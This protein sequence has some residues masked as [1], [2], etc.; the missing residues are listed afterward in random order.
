MRK[1]GTNHKNGIFVVVCVMCAILLLRCLPS[2]DYRFSALNGRSINAANYLSGWNSRGKA[3]DVMKRPMT[4]TL[5]VLP[6]SL[7]N[8]SYDDERLVQHIR[9]H[10][11]IPPSVGPRVLKTP[12][13]LDYS[14]RN[15]SGIVDTILGGLEGGFFVECGAGN[16]QTYSNSLFLEKVRGWTGLLVEANPHHFSSMLRKNRYAYLLNACLS[17]RPY[18]A[19]LNFSVA[20]LLG[21]LP[22]YIDERQKSRM[23]RKRQ[24]SNI[25]I[26]CFPLASVLKALHRSHVDYFSLDV[27]G[28]EIDIMRTLP[29][30]RFTFSAMTVEYAVN[31]CDECSERRLR[32]LDDIILSTGLYSKWGIAG[33]LDVVY[34]QKQ[35]Q[36]T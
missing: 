19:I 7:I 20:K 16:G 21:G 15:Q 33:E 8:A 14:Q 18:A 17:P 34:V 4:W 28:A 25:S 5:P 32:D 31:M 30:S 6:D 12:D 3:A 22:Q 9:E 24:Y 2:V 23:A 35:H 29:F 27:E 26:P 36:R 1:L 10:W 11:L 13:R